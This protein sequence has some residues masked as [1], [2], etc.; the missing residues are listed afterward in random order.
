MTRLPFR[1]LYREF[2]FR[3]VDLE[4]IA[5]QGD[6]TRLLGQFTGLLLFLSSVRALGGL[7]FDSRGMSEAALRSA[8][9]GH[10]HSLIA[11]TML[12]VG[13][14]AVLSWDSAF[15]DRRDLL[16]LLPLPLATRTIFLAKLA[17]LGSAL[18]LTVAALNSCTGLIFPLHFAPAGS[19]LLGV[20]RAMAAYWVTMFAAGA[21]VFLSLLTV[22]GIAAQLPRWLFLRL[23][24]WLQMM[25]LGLILGVSLLQPSPE[26]AM[27][28]DR[29]LWWPSYWFLGLFQQWNGSMRPEMAALAGR[30]WLACAAAIGG[31]GG[32][33]LLAYFR[34][35]RKIVEQPD[36]LPAVAGWR[37][38]L[39]FQRG[40]KAAI[41]YFSVRTL[42]RSRQHRVILAFYLGA[43]FTAVIG[44]TK[45]AFPARTLSQRLPD[46]LLLASF[47]LMLLW[48]VGTRV[49][50]AMPLELRANWIFRITVVGERAACL[51]ASRRSLVLLSLVPAW[52]ISAA[53][54][55]WRFPWR[56]VAGHMVVLGLVGTILADLSMH[57]FPKIPF[58]CSYL[59]GKSRVHL[60]FLGGAILING[61]PPALRFEM[62]ALEDRAAY[63]QM[64]LVLLAAAG[65]ARWWAWRLTRSRET[66]VR[67]EEEESPAIFA[68]DLRKD[69]V[70]EISRGTS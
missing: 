23:S 49:V 34:T 32:V 11:M 37:W 60:I 3:L 21:F 8:L 20:M 40:I 45:L 64:L 38:P 58:T 69:G 66:E 30:A 12:V 25:A 65:G 59:P 19:G 47:L 53:L 39:P 55:L 26:A 9:W 43:A 42:L 48:V 46:P 7:F 5:P 70:R 15:P 13:L 50:F 18:G 61:V 14:F 35:L 31:A 51:A 22:Q 36:I 41:T 10:E 54:L 68:L 2:L 1:V 16:V 63:W 33:F 17:A 27:H 62:R 4:L 24:S 44:L 57:G 28:G 6:I 56:I 67:Y 52:G 29:F